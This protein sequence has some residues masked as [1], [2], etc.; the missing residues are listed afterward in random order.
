MR[1]LVVDT[2]PLRIS[3][4]FRRLWWGLSVSQLGTQLTVVAVGLQVYAITGSTLSVGV[5]GMFAFVPLVVFGLYGGAIVDHYDRRKVALVASAVSWVAILVLAVQGWAGNEHVGTLYALTA[6]QSG[7]N[8]VNSPARSAII[9]RLLG[10]RYMPAANAL[11]AIGFQTALMVGPLAGAGLASLDYGLA[12]TVD[13]ALFTFALAAVFRLPPV[14][15]EPSDSRR[16][17]VGLGSVVDGL[18]YLGTQPNLRMTFAVDLC[19]MI[20]AMP[21]VVFPAVGIW[22]LGGGET[23]T[24]ILTAALAVGAVTSGLLSGGLAR[25]R[26]QGRVITWAITGW[27]LSVV[28]FGL[29]L[30]LVGRD[31]PDHVLWGALAIACCTLVAAGASDEVSA[32][33]RQTILQTATPDDM[34]GRLQGV[35]IVVVAGGPRLGDMF[36]GSVSGAVGEAWAVVIGGLL[37]VTL[38]WLLVRT[39]RT[40]WRYDAHH[41]TP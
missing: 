1:S 14:V 10:P 37:C 40:F 34:R 19:A 12:Y 15:P 33:F 39:Q 28:G 41:P 2:T 18:R 24:G 13:A 22:Y 4:D 7:A 23:T 21:R 3:P 32:I 27:G 20:L 36:I 17:R 25:V 16:A 35:F 26:W 29:V 8:A 31:R 38:L 5:L 11:Q 6:I 9:P 30:V